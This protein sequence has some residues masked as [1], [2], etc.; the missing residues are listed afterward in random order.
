[1]HAQITHTQ[2]HNDHSAHADLRRGMGTTG[3]VGTLTAVACGAGKI[4]VPVVT[5][6]NSLARP[7]SSCPAGFGTHGN[8]E[9]TFYSADS[10][11][12]FGCVFAPGDGWHNGLPQTCPIGT[13]GAGLANASC[14][15]CCN[16]TLTLSAGSDSV[17]DCAT[18]TAAAVGAALALDSGATAWLSTGTAAV[19]WSNTSLTGS[20]WK[21][22]AVSATGSIMLAADGSGALYESSNAGASW[23][24]ASGVSGSGWTGAAASANGAKLAATSG[25][26]GGSIWIKSGGA[27]AQRPVYGNWSDIAMASSA[28]TM[29]AVQAGATGKIFVSQDSGTTWAEPAGGQPT[30]GGSWTAVACSADCRWA[31]AAQSGSAGSLFVSSD[32]GTTWAVLPGWPTGSWSSVASSGTFKRIIAGQAGT[33]GKLYVGSY[34][35]D[36]WSWSHDAGLLTDWSSVAASYDGSVLVAA[37]RALTEGNGGIWRSID[38]GSSW[39]SSVSGPGWAAIA[40]S[41]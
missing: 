30:G 15:M 13:Y 17:D 21:A 27:W 41:A 37:S 4:G 40:L 22:I 33:L 16:G 14:S 39:S 38:S 24:A 6:G 28:A 29:I 35:S 18:Y 9:A 31:V 8:S 7:C 5:Y 2:L 20:Q 25:S 36:S 19:V 11:G 34:A 1:M 12:Y 3:S 10:G 32:W 23:S 26:S